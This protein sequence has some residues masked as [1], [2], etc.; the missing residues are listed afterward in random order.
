MSTIANRNLPLEDLVV[1]DFG[2]VV[3][4]PHGSR[5]LADL[6]ATVIKCESPQKMDGIRGD[7]VRKGSLGPA[8]EA[9]CVFLEANRNKYGVSLNAKTERGRVVLKRL[10][11]KADIVVSNSNPKGFR[12][13]GITWDDLKEF[14]PGIIIINASGLGDWGPYSNFV[15]Y[16]PNLQSLCGLNGTIGYEGAGPVGIALPWADYMG[17]MTV[18]L[19]ALAAVEYRRKTGKGQFIDVSQHE[20][21]LTFIGPLLLDYAANGR[22]TNPRGNRHPAKSAAPHGA[23]RCEGENRWCAISVASEQ[24]WESFCNAIGNP[25]WAREEKFETHLQRVINQIELDSYVTSWTAGRSAEEASGILQKSG[26]SAAVVKNVKDL[27]NDK[28]LRERGFLDNI[29]LPEVPDATP[30]SID[31]PGKIIRLMG[32]SNSIDRSGPIK[33][34]QD[35]DYVYGKL[36]GMSAD[37]VKEAQE[38]GAI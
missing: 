29:G 2:W 14:N 16:G 20:S 30:A 1:L 7:F 5:A 12:S 19:T 13:L 25:S 4:G 35:N 22:I 24:E 31:L 37:E 23:F 33:L 34:G 36:L 38:Q 21:A 3:A 28:H 15:T 17:G 32:W 10:V 27:F 11:E 18:A 26:V 8:E 9:G 6:G